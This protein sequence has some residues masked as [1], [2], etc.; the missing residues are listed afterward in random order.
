MKNPYGLHDEFAYRYQQ[1]IMIFGRDFRSRSE[2]ERA[3]LLYRIVEQCELA[4]K[5]EFEREHLSREADREA[6][7]DAKSA[8]KH[9]RIL[10]NYLGAYPRQTTFALMNA[11]LKSEVHLRMHVDPTPMETTSTFEDG[12]DC[13]GKPVVAMSPSHSMRLSL[14]L[15]GLAEEIEA[16]NLSAKCGPFAHRTRHGP[17]GYHKPIDNVAATALP[18]RETAL[19]IYLSFLFRKYEAERQIFIM[20]GELYPKNGKPHWKLVNL[21][22]CDTFEITGDFSEAAKART[23]GDCKLQMWGYRR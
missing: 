2:E 17:L 9:A 22:V 5:F 15:N 7:A 18:T 20:T 19:A 8:A 1:S 21:L 23:K 12:C 10:A 4:R 16:G 13:G 3:G 6:I 14:L 11:I